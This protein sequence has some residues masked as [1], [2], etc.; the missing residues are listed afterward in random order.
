VKGLGECNLRKTSIIK[1][2]N[3]KLDGLFK[4]KEGASLGRKK[5]RMKEL[6][7]KSIGEA[8]NRSKAG[9][10]MVWVECKRGV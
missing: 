5:S 8:R 6:Y 2:T 10:R 9:K 7:I 3:I 1:G 4:L